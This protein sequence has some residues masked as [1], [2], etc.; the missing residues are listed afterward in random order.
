[1]KLI[2]TTYSTGHCCLSPPSIRLWRALCISMIWAPCPHPYDDDLDVLE[3]SHE[4]LEK[5]REQPGFRN[6][7]RKGETGIHQQDS[8]CEHQ[9]HKLK[10]NVPHSLG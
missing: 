10:C 5:G 9:L 3:I 8:A 7:D 2:K 4:P 1:M 6:R